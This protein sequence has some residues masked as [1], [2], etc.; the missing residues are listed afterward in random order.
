[1]PIPTG[2][3]RL[4]G[5]TLLFLSP[6]ICGADAVSTHW[7][8]DLVQQALAQGQSAQLSPHLSVLLGLTT[9]ERS[10][11]V[12]QLGIRSDAALWLFDVCRSPHAPI[13]LMRV[14]DDRHVS[15]YRI[16][17]RGRPLRAVAYEIGGAT[18][19]LPAQQSTVDFRRQVD[20]WRAQQQSLQSA[21]ERSA[22]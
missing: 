11:P 7:L 18:Q 16:T 8:S 15:V 2:K 22:P 14:G 5:L 1:M 12:Q 9:A 6:G 17:T 21:R 10:T 19:L 4:V 20:F 13:V 3:R